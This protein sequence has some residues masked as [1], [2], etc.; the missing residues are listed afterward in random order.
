MLTDIE[1]AQQGKLLP[2]SEIAKRL[3]I[4]D[5]ALV[6]Y[7]RTKAQDFARLDRGSKGVPTAS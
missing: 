2:I 1:I 4:P 5:D 6:P 3:A 7:G